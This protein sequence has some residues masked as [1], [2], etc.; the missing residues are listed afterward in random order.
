MMTE[1]E[2][3]LYLAEKWDN[4]KILNGSSR[5]SATI[6]HPETGQEFDVETVCGSI[7]H[8]HN[9]QVSHETYRA[10]RRHMR[11]EMLQWIYSDLGSRHAYWWGNDQDGAKK[12]AAFCR[13]M[14]TIPNN[15]FGRKLWLLRRLMLRL[16][17]RI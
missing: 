4:A 3:W 1:K 5:V 8:L 13:E 6:P 15:F 7:N 2:A 10:M 11:S 14:A 12:R 16:L 9:T 17:G